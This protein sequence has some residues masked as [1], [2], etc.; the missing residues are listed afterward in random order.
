M[1][2]VQAYYL[3][4]GLSSV[5]IAIMAFGAYVNWSR[6]QWYGAK[7][8]FVRSGL[9]FIHPE[10]I[11]SE[12]R[13]AASESEADYFVEL[14]WGQETVGRYGR[15]GPAAVRTYCDV[16]ILKRGA[17]FNPPATRVWGADPPSRIVRRSS[18]VSC[19]VSGAYPAAAVERYL[20]STF[21]TKRKMFYWLPEKM[22]F[23]KTSR[24]GK[25]V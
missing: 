9:P 19:P 3:I 7:K 18:D 17:R 23:R 1:T 2:P 6:R 20:W 12:D 24:S 4:A 15:F 22:D 11:V 21:S 10:K 25:H 16:R 14:H 5:V 13:I 8:V